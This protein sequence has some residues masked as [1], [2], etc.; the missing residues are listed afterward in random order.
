LSDV[1]EYGVLRLLDELD[2][3]L[4]AGRYRPLPARRVF[5]S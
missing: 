1:E 5:I 2:T 3:D 4:R